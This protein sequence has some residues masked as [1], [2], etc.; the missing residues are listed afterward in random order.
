MIISNRNIEKFINY[1]GKKLNAPQQ[2][3]VM[4]VTAVLFQPY[5][6]RKNKK[7]DND[8][9]DMAVARS[10]GKN[11][12]GNF[13]DFITRVAS[14]FAVGGLSKYIINDVKN[15]DDLVTE[16]SPKNKI[17]DI[18]TPNLKENFIQR[19]HKEFLKDYKSYRMAMGALL[20][21]GIAVFVK[22][23][24]ELPVTKKLTEIFYKREKSKGKH[25]D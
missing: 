18:L 24:V 23:T 19:P 21:T 20:A 6:N 13:F 7:L 15:E 25:N 9:R 10:I 12:T 1:S 22:T 11:I 5:I 3:V 8:T 2:S 17:K 14:I 16:I 4:G